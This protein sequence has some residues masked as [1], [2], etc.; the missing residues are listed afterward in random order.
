MAAA[1]RRASSALLAVHNVTGG[2]GDEIV[3]VIPLIQAFLDGNPSLTVTVL[4]KRPYL[5]DHP[6]VSSVSILDARAVGRAL[7]DRFDGIV[8]WNAR[9]VPEASIRADLAQRHLAASELP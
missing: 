1:V 5:Y 3:R 2:Q 8:D 9:S 7:G 6:R 4:S